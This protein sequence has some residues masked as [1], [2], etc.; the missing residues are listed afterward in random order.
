[1][2]IDKC[3]FPLYE[4]R[5]YRP[6]L[7]INIVNPHTKLHYKTYGIIDTGADDCAIPAFIAKIIGH[8]LTDGKSIQVG[9]GNGVTSA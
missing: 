6:A 2:I 5:F 8:N 9:T 4:D 7:P 1:M 3:P